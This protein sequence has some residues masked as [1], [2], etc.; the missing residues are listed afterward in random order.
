MAISLM[1][2]YYHDNITG[3]KY[4]NDVTRAVVSLHVETIEE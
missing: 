1:P 2:V 3:Q 4:S